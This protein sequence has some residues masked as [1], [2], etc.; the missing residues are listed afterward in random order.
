MF[1]AMCYC[2]WQANVYSVQ[3]AQAAAEA[4]FEKIEEAQIAF[5]SQKQR[6]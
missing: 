4:K 6:S 5:E 2:C 3:E 1:A